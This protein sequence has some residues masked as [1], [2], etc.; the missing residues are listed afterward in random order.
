MEETFKSISVN[1]IEHKGVSQ[2]PQIPTDLSTCDLRMGEVKLYGAFPSPFAY[3]IKC[4]LNQGPKFTRHEKKSPFAR[5]PTDMTNV[6]NS[7]AG[8]TTNQF[9]IFVN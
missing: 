9:I 1:C 7:H 6:W 8:K 2:Q 4:A 5:F 3:K